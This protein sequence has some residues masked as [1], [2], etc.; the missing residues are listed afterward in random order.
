MAGRVSHRAFR[1]L[2]YTKIWLIDWFADRLAGTVGN[3]GSEADQW[4]E[5]KLFD[6]LLCLD[7][8]DETVFD[9]RTM[10]EGAL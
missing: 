2:L 10:K 3:D 6:V 5:D 7:E 9:V 4:D 1:V 8:W